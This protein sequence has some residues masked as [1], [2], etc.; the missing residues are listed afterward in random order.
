MKI[1]FRGY[2]TKS[3]RTCREGDER[4]RYTLEKKI[5][6]LKWYLEGA[7]I[8]SIERMEEVSATLIVYWI[9]KMGSMLREKRGGPR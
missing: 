4:V 5:R 9:R 1:P 3:K 8:R 6:V 7:G 2:A